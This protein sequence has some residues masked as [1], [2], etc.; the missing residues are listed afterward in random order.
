MSCARRGTAAIST[1][2][3]DYAREILDR[4]SFLEAH[5]SD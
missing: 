2:G 4:A 1:S 3:R 5:G